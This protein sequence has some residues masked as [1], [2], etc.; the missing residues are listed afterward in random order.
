MS[1]Y[2]QIR[3]IIAATLK[4][5]PERISETSTSEDLPEWD[6][7]AHVNLMMAIEQ[8]FDIDLEIDDFP[9]LVSVSAII[10]YLERRLD[11]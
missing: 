4:I 2:D 3:E 11:S 8:T 7:L 9:E 1:R 10:S 6:S 5:N